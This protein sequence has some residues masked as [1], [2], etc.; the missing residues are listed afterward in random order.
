MRIIKGIKSSFMCSAWLFLPAITCFA[1][2]SEATSKQYQIQDFSDEYYATIKSKAYTDDDSESNVTVEI[3]DKKTKKL[4]ISQAAGIDLD[5]EL[6]NSKE[7]GLGE[8]LSANI[9]SLPYGEHSVLIY[10]DFNFDNIPDLAIQDGR[11]G[12]YGGTSYQVYLKQGSRFVHS[13]GFTELAHGNCG[14]F[15]VDE[16]TQTL[17]TMT[18]SGAAWHQYSDY[19]VINN[20]PV[21][22]RII[23][24][25]Y[26]SKGL[27]SIVEK[28]RVNGKMIEQQYQQLIRDEG[29]D[30]SR[31]VYGF[32]LDN[33][34]K[35]VLDSYS[36]NSG[37]HLYYAF[38]DN[39]DKVELYYDGPFVYD[40]K[41]KTLSFTNKPVVYQIDNQGINV[42]NSNKTFLLKAKMGSVRGSL[43]NLARFENVRVR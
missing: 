43:E 38:A 41:Q 23:E 34:K 7:Q 32:D 30:S 35:M 9:V 33:N 16:E 8:Q 28:T 5:Y 18:K 21:A 31:Y 37:D 1:Q 14:F 20:K 17:H 13:K 15:D 2:N 24:E 10:D 11:W 19:K 4:L 27:L 40:S 26:N 12:C 39:D 22:V 6:E 25:E 42:R 36:E 3:K 29:D